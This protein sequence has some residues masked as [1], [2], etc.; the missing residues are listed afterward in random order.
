MPSDND[1]NSD[2]MQLAILEE[3][4]DATIRRAEI[5]GEW[6]FSVIGVVAILTDS[7]A[8]AAGTGS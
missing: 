6:Y 5:N 2:N 8:P 7:T 3:Q 4:A 1:E